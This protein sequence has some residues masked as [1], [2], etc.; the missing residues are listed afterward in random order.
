MRFMMLMLPKGYDQAPAGA[1][2]DVKMAA[3]MMKY[4]QSLKEAGV[5]LALDGLH[6]PAA[7]VR[8]KFAGGK[9]TAVDGP[10]LEAKEVVGGYWLI[11]V[12]SLEE[13]I[14][15][16]KRSPFSPNGPDQETEIE[17]REFIEFE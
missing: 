7:G 4:N 13:A 2:P 6:P 16:A 9:A 15:W 10:F 11:Q 1:L 3:A 14:E 8:V 5:L 12:K 17:V